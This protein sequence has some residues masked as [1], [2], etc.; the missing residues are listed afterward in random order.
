M[1]NKKLAA[2]TLPR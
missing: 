2:I 1:D